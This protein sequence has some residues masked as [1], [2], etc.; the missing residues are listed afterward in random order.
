MPARSGDR[1]LLRFAA[2]L[3]VLGVW[4]ALGGW[5]LFSLAAGATTVL[6]ATAAVGAV[7]SGWQVALRRGAFLAVFLGAA[8]AAAGGAAVVATIR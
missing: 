4:T 8:L 6:P 7:A 5:F 1:P 3:L 2:R